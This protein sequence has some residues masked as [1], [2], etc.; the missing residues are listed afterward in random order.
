[1]IATVIML[2]NMK[3]MTTVMMLLKMMRITIKNLI[4]T[5][6][7]RLGSAVVM[8]GKAGDEKKSMVCH[9]TGSRKS[10]ARR[11]KNHER[12][13]RGKEIMNEEN[14][15]MAGEANGESMRKKKVKC[16]EVNWEMEEIR[17]EQEQEGNVRK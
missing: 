3:M 2:M 13:R 9:C 16:A 4:L 14:F 6:V 11:K 7:T 17:Q 12:E 15:A 1:M 5:S 8:Y 10:V